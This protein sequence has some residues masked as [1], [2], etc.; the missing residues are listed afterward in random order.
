MG[1]PAAPFGTRCAGTL[2]SSRT[3]LAVGRAGR[4]TQTLPWDARGHGGPPPTPCPR[5]ICPATDPRCAA[6]RAVA[7]VPDPTQR[8]LL[9]QGPRRGAGRGSRGRASSSTVTSHLDPAGPTGP[10]RA[11][12]PTRARPRHP[13]HERLARPVAPARHRR[14][15]TLC[16]LA[17]LTLLQRPSGRW[18]S[19]ADG[20]DATPRAPTRRPQPRLLPP[21]QAPL[22]HLDAPARTA[23]V[24]L[25][26]RALRHG[27]TQGSSADCSACTR[28]PQ[29]HAPDL[30]G[31]LT[32]PP[33]QPWDPARPRGLTCPKCRGFDAR[34]RRNGITWS[35]H[36]PQRLLDVETRAL[37][38]AGAQVS[39][40]RRRP[41]NSTAPGGGATGPPTARKGFSGLFFS[42]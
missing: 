4:P 40:C 39:Q 32:P 13:R 6:R 27:R 15:R 8:A 35:R 41:N 22:G 2:R 29:T 11:T 20:T 18:G 3:L 21:G 25:T 14:P 24:I 17:D 16:H 26:A 38:E 1:S 28:I 33:C 42:S 10:A 9:E 36:L 34:L 5:A 12:G 7:Q 31:P 19:L 23:L 30:R 37:T